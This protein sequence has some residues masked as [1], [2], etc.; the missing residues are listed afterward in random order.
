MFRPRKG[1]IEDRISSFEV[2]KQ[3]NLPLAQKQVTFDKLLQTNPRLVFLR[4]RCYNRAFEYCHLKL[5][6]RG[7][8]RLSEC[9]KIPAIYFQ[10]TSNKK[11][12][13]EISAMTFKKIKN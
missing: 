6:R 5:W 2:Q 3:A 10:K 9:S 1:K 13:F 7:V 4:V 12:N 8:R 11:N